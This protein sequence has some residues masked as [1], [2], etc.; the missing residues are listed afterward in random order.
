LSATFLQKFAEA[1]QLPRGDLEKVLHKRP[2]MTIKSLA[3][4]GC[5]SVVHGGDLKAKL[6]GGGENLPL[7]FETFLSQGEDG[8]EESLRR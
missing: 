2:F 5:T 4:T 7:A 8:K 1:A 3:R 6:G